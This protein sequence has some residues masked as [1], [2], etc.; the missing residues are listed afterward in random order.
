MI[1]GR[2][3]F[4]GFFDAEVEA[5]HIYAKAAYK[6]KPKKTNLSMF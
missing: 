2:V 4:L 3:R 6:Y 5:A 1:E